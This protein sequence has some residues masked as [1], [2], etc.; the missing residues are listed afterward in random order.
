MKTILKLHDLVPR[1][2]ELRF[3]KPINSGNQRRRTMGDYRT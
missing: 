2:P 1:I 3:R